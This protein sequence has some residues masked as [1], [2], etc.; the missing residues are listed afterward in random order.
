MR[1]TTSAKKAAKTKTSQVKNGKAKDKRPE[2]GPRQEEESQEVAI[3]EI[4]TTQAG[5]EQPE[6]TLPPYRAG[7]PDCGEF[8]LVT[9]QKIRTWRV[10]RCRSCGWRGEMEG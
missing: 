1:P 7:C 3:A 10:C 8:P 5:R 4:R 9:E 2:E 6:P